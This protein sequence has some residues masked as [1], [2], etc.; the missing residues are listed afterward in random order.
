MNATQNPPTFRQPIPTTVIRDG[1]IVHEA[2]S[3]EAANRWAQAASHVDGWREYCCCQRWSYGNM[4]GW[5]LL[6]RWRAGKRRSNALVKKVA[7]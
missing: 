5:K 3:I 2:D 6:Q 4:T 1:G 7:A